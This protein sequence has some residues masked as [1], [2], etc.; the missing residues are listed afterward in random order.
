MKHRHSVDKSLGNHMLTLI[1]K[2]G[3]RAKNSGIFEY[4]QRK[5]KF[6]F[7]DE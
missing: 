2:R 5:I 3:L 6:I 4:R 1:D 7:Y